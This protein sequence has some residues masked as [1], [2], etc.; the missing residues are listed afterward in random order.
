MQYIVCDQQSVRL[1][2]N[3]DGGLNLG[4]KKKKKKKKPVAD[5]VSA[6]FFPGQTSLSAAVCTVL[7]HVARAARRCSVIHSPSTSSTT[8]SPL[9]TNHRTSTLLSQGSVARLPRNLNVA[10]GLTAQARSATLCS[11]LHH[12]LPCPAAGPAV[13]AP[14]AAQDEALAEA[15]GGATEEA[16]GE[17]AAEDLGDLGAPLDLGL[18]KKKKKKKAKVSPALLAPIATACDGTMASKWFGC[19]K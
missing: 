8:P 14:A 10:Q 2:V 13:T 16:D 19:M 17:G 7:Q 9:C 11:P 6:N 12:A 18:G 15:T 3:D 4:E 1:A 5:A